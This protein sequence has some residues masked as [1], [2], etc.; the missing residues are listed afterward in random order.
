MY[1]HT[2]CRIV[3]ENWIMHNEV[4]GTV[5]LLLKW[6]SYVFEDQQSI[7]VTNLLSGKDK[8]HSRLITLYQ[9]IHPTLY[10]YYLVHFLG[11]HSDIA[12]DGQLYSP[13]FMLLDC[14]RFCNIV[15]LSMIHDAKCP[16]KFSS[17]ARVYLFCLI[18]IYLWE[19]GRNLEIQGH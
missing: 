13:T 5:I 11:L 19:Q 10:M 9:L 2:K 15:P 7:S 14:I 18:C 3:F 6:P 17:L 1:S 4:T 8:G 16:E 12:E